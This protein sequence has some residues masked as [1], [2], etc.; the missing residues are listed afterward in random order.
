MLQNKKS[1][2]ERLFLVFPILFECEYKY[3]VQEAHA[4]GK[5][6]PDRR[7]FRKACNFGIISCEKCVLCIVERPDLPGE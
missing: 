3:S 7:I 6:D 1:M 5:S 2:G 4:T